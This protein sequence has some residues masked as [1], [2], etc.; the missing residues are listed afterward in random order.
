MV[1]LIQLLTGPL[2]FLVKSPEEL[3]RLIPDF[4]RSVPT[5]QRI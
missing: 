5:P 1:P 2:N 4:E 3:R